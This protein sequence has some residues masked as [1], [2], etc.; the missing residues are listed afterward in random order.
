MW[1][2]RTSGA[3][4]V[5]VNDGAR[6][7]FRSFNK[8]QGYNSPV[9]KRAAFA[10]TTALNYLLRRESPQRLQVGDTSQVFWADKPVDLETSVVDIFGE[11]TQGRSDS[12][13][14]AVTSLYK[15]ID[16]GLLENDEGRARF[17]VLGLAPNGARI[18]IRFWHHGTVAEM[19]GEYQTATSTI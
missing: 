5:A 2:A 19:A 12:N 4:I 15:A 14:R 7:A 10:Y 17:F 3:N 11:P 1:G 9:G 6:P 13:V 16:L 8:S 18:A